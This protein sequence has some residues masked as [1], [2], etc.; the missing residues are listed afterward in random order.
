M[1]DEAY[2]EGTAKIADDFNDATPNPFV[3]GDWRVMLNAWAGFALRVILVVSSAFGINQYLII[4]EESRVSRAL[5]LVE[6]WE[7]PEY[8]KAQSER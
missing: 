5:E 8:Q 3:E 1:P 7:K 2:P 6:L 4:R